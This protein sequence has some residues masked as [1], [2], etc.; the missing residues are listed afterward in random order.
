[1]EQLY[2]YLNDQNDVPVARSVHARMNTK[3]EPGIYLL[4]FFDTLTNRLLTSRLLSL[5]QTNQLT[6]DC[7]DIRLD[8]SFK[9][10]R[11]GG[12]R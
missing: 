10:T 7:P 8:A 3:L 12:A 11:I 4:Q 9:L 1:M 6:L 2:H 5:K